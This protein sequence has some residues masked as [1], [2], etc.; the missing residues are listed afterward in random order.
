MAAGLVLTYRASGV[1]NL[2]FGAQ[3]YVSAIVFYVAVADGWPKWAAFVVAVVVFGPALGSRSTGCSSS[4]RARRRRSS[5][6][7]RRSGF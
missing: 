3:A 4:T 2:A 5:D 1:F 6:S 7:S